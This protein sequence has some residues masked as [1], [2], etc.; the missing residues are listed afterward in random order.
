[1]MRLSGSTSAKNPSQR[2]AIPI[3][4]FMAL[5]R[6]AT[7]FCILFDHRRVIVIGV[8]SRVVL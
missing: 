8:T 5:L 6:D 4:G 7:G 3:A 2:V 1:M